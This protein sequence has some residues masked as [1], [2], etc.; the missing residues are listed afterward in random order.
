MPE[1]TQRKKNAWR[2]SMKTATHTRR[3]TRSIR[4]IILFPNYLFVHRA[5][6]SVVIGLTVWWAVAALRFKLVYEFMFI[7]IARTMCSINSATSGVRGVQVFAPVWLCM[8]ALRVRRMMELLK[9]NYLRNFVC[10]SISA[11]EYN[12]FCY[13]FEY[14]FACFIFCC[15]L[16]CFFFWVKYVLRKTENFLFVSS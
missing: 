5:Y 2:L 7:W 8:C 10:Q 12:A 6:T 9:W 15:F 13:L 11:N 14:L 16:W 4:Q 1:K 3:P